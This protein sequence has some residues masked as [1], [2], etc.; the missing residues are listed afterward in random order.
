MHEAITHGAT[1]D[2]VT[3]ETVT[4]TDGWHGMNRAARRRWISEKRRE[5][6]R[7]ARAQTTGTLSI[8]GVDL[9]ITNVRA[10]YG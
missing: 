4:P 7:Q 8:D 3:I 9:R 10:S 5:L 1:Q 6:R 2:D